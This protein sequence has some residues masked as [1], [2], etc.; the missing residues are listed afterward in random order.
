MNIFHSFFVFEL[1]IL[2]KEEK[3]S[4]NF[5]FLCNSMDFDAWMNEQEE[6]VKNWGQNKWWWIDFWAMLESS[7]PQPQPPTNTS[8]TPQWNPQQWGNQSLGQS[9]SDDVYSVGEVS[10]QSQST[11]DYQIQTNKW[12]YKWAFTNL[13]TAI[14]IPSDWWNT[15]QTNQIPQKSFS[16]VVKYFWEVNKKIYSSFSMLQL[17]F[18]VVGMWIAWYLL[19]LLKET[20]VY[21]ILYNA[22]YLDFFWG[23]QSMIIL[24]IYIVV[25]YG[26]LE[27]LDWF[28]DHWRATL[29][30]PFKFW[31]IGIWLLYLSDTLTFDQLFNL[32]YIFL[33][34][35]LFVRLFC[36]SEE[37]MPKSLATA[38][39]EAIENNQAQITIPQENSEQDLINKWKEAFDFALPTQESTDLLVE[40]SWDVEEM[41]DL[42][43]ELIAANKERQASWFLMSEKLK[44]YYFDIEQATEPA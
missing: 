33:I 8:W 34:P 6:E 9:V 13:Q 11:T 28:N 24:L 32:F 41:Y 10:G 4:I 43:S 26:L 38:N 37:D 23:M 5:L 3:Y 16:E 15:T 18:I 22:Q 19:W 14:E 20:I 2:L 1:L 21:L 40:E 35:L 7:N 12:A 27:I 25:V 42:G 44:L 39:N 29:Q 30:M 17:A 36:F 31:L